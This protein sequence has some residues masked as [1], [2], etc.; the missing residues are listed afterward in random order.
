MEPKKLF[1]NISETVVVAGLLVVPTDLNYTLPV[2]Y[3]RVS[4]KL[5]K[6]YVYEFNRTD[7]NMEYEN[8]YIMT[9]YS[10]R[11]LERDAEDLFGPMREA[12]QEE[13]KSVEDYIESISVNTGVKFF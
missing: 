12:T 3:Q 9:D 10:Y 11:T 6:E 8:N 7:P 4:N 1:P 2:N 5:P 13:Q